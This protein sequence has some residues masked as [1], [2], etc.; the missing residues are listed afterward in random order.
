MKKI[1][2]L[3]AA[4]LMLAACQSSVHTVSAGTPG[5]ESC[6]VIRGDTAGSGKNIIYRCSN[7][8]AAINA[9]TAAG[10]LESGIPVSFGGGGVPVANGRNLVTRQAANGVGKSDSEA[11][12]RALINAARKFQ[13]TAGKLGGRGVTG[14]HS[15]LDKQP[16]QGGQYDCQAGS[17]HVRVVM[18]ANVVR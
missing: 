13:Q 12:E 4:A 15:Y 1:F 11:C 7:G 2:I 3:S 18:R 14:F 10:V 16:L 6:K 8:Q 5:G 9:A 17:F